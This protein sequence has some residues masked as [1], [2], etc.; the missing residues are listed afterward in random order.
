MLN[1][2]ESIIEALGGPTATA[3]IVGVVPS[4]IN[5]WKT[6]GEIPSDKFML[7]ERALADRGKGKPSPNLFG[8]KVPVK[9]AK[10]G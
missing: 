8:F 1:T 5:N 9:T 10:S 3:T 7:L 6:R 2:V 4:A